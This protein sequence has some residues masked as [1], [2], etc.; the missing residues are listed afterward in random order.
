[1]KPGLARAAA[2]ALF[3]LALAVPAAA[4]LA[5]PAPQVP[6]PTAFSGGERNA[7]AWAHSLQD[8]GYTVRALVS[9]APLALE[10]PR[11]QQALVVVLAPTA[12][13]RL[14]GLAL[15]RFLADGGRVWVADPDGNANPW[16]AAHGIAVDPHRLLDPGLAHPGAARLSAAGKAFQ[17][18]G[19]TGSL[20]ADPDAGWQPLW[21]AG[22]GV[23]RDMD[24]NGSVDRTDPPGPH[25]VAATLAT[26]GGGRL[27]VSADA[28]AFTDAALAA[29]GTRDAVRAA[30]AA[31]LPDGGTV[32]VDESQHG[33]TRAEAPAA[34]LLSLTAWVGVAP[35]WVRLLLLLPALAGAALLLRSRG[36]LEPYRSHQMVDPETPPGHAPPPEP[37]D[38][39]LMP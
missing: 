33:W 15:D 30:V 36:G 10:E 6:A 37:I 27:V 17:T 16:L 1:M 14:D 11:P 22:A 28:S 20:L 34:T 7:T 25:L 35:P 5:A 29:P 13:D 9:G 38:R 3:A 12:I 39:K 8:A 19:P 32:L 24:G 18:A 26:A 23:H 31:L 21:Q 2:Y 4:W